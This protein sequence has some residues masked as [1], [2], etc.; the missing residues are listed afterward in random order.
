ML[1]VALAA[2]LLAGGFFF[3]NSRQATEKAVPTVSV[4]IMV[5]DTDPEEN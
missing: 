1:L 3:F 5:P 2:A 4:E